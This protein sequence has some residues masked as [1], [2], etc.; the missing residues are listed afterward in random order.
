MMMV[1]S[2]I[3]N[4]GRALL[5]Y[6][7]RPA[8]TGLAV[9]IALLAGMPAAQALKDRP[10][11]TVCRRFTDTSPARVIGIIEIGRHVKKLD[12][13]SLFCFVEMLEDQVADP[14]VIY[15]A[16]YATFG[17]EDYIPL[18]ADQAWYLYDCDT[19]DDQKTMKPYTYAFASE[20]LAKQYQDEL[21]GE[22]LN[23][24]DVVEKIKALTDDWEPPGSGYDYRPL[25]RKRV[26]HEKD[27]DKDK[28]DDDSGQDK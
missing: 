8:L 17:T 13:C 1:M 3:L 21:G 15:V 9:L 16:D 18:K 24:D 5:R 27:K 19:G 28:N 12:A 25:N 23:W 11:C 26:H 7:A 4:R 2:E 10:I 6:G 14:T 20:E 22:V